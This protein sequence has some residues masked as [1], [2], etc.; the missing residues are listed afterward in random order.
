MDELLRKRDMD[1]ADMPGYTEGM[2]FPAD[3]HQII[4]HARKQHLPP[5]VIR[6]LKKLPDKKYGNV[7]ELIS[8]AAKETD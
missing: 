2:A 6:R 4:E 8:A 7:S 3:K 5:D 1:N